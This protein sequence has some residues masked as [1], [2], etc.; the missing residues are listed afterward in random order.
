LKKH[1]HV[2]VV[3]LVIMLFQAPFLLAKFG[4]VTF[5]QLTYQSEN[6]TEYISI[7]GFK[8][9]ELNEKCGAGGA[10]LNIWLIGKNNLQIELQKVDAGVSIKFICGISE[11]EQSEVISSNKKG[12]FISVELNGSDFRKN[13]KVSLLKKFKSA[14][15]FKN[16]LSEGGKSTEK[17]IIKYAKSVYKHFKSKTPIGF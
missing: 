9:I 3:V 10:P 11:L 8:V 13:E 5:S 2:Y 6:L 16:H 1:I 17:E 15:D 7:N 14:L 4:K 12:A